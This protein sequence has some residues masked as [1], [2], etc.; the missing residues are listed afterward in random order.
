MALK[1][2]FGIPIV[3]S[4][5][6]NAINMFAENG[7]HN[8][9][10]VAEEL[11]R[12]EEGFKATKQLFG[13]GKTLNLTTSKS[14][15][16][17][18]GASSSFEAEQALRKLKPGSPVTFY[19]L[20]TIGTFGE[21]R[22]KKSDL[23]FF[24][25][26]EFALQDT[27]FTGN[28]FEPT[29]KA[30]S[31]SMG[32]RQKS[33][34]WAKETLTKLENNPDYYHQMTEAE[35]FALADL[36]LYDDNAKFGKTKIDGMLFATVEAQSPNK[37]STGWAMTDAKNI[38]RMREGL[39]NKTDSRYITPKTNVLDLLHNKG[40]AG[41]TYAGQN[42]RAFDQPGLAEVVAQMSE[43][44]GYTKRRSVAKSVAKAQ[45]DVL[46]LNTQFLNTPGNP[47]SRNKKLSVM[48]SA[49]G[50]AVGDTHF[51]QADVETTIKVANASIPYWNKNNVIQK[52]VQQHVRN[53]DIFI[54][55]RGTGKYK[56]NGYRRNAGKYDVTINRVGKETALTRSFQESPLIEGHGYKLVGQYDNVQ[57]DGKNM[58]ALRFQDVEDGTERIIYR[59][60]KAELANV[61]DS[62]LSRTKKGIPSKQLQAQIKNA[63]RDA[64]RRFY[65]SLYEP[66]LDPDMKA[67]QKRF[68]GVY[69]VLDTYTAQRDALAKTG[70]TGDDL[71]RQAILAAQ[72]EL[73]KEGNPL[74]KFLTGYEKV[75]K[76]AQLEGVL[77][78]ERSFMGGI[79]GAIGNDKSAHGITVQNQMVQTAHDLWLKR[80]GNAA[81]EF[82]FDGMRRLPISTAR[83]ATTYI[84]VESPDAIAER[85][86]K[87]LDYGKGRNVAKPFQNAK[88]FL[89]GFNLTAAERVQFEE[90]LRGE[91]SKSNSVSE[92]TT[93]AIANR[94]FEV[95]QTDERVVSRIPGQKLVAPIGPGKVMPAPLNEDQLDYL[96]T[97]VAKS[98]KL[99]D[100]TI[101]SQAVVKDYRGLFTPSDLVRE[102]IQRNDAISEFFDNQ[103]ATKEIFS[104]PKHGNTDAYLSE[105]LTA[106]RGKY[107]IAMDYVPETDRVVFSFGAPNVNIAGMTMEEK[108]LDER[109]TQFNLPFYNRDATVDVNG[110]GLTNQYD[111]VFGDPALG[112]AI[113]KMGITS[114]QD[115]AWTRIA[116][117]PER[118]EREMARAKATGQPISRVEAAKRAVQSYGSAITS[119]Q[120]SRT[121]AGDADPLQSY[122]HGS[123]QRNAISGQLIKM[124]DYSD[125]L[126][127][128]DHERVWEEYQIWK[129]EKHYRGN[130]L[131]SDFISPTLKFRGTQE[132]RRDVRTRLEYEANES[133][134]KTFGFELSNAGLNDKQY[135]TGKFYLR[136]MT[137]ATP[138][139]ER[140]Q[141]LR[142]NIVK[143]QNYHV[144]EGEPMRQ[145]LRGMGYSES[146]IDRKLQFGSSEFYEDL[147]T[148][149]QQKEMRG[150]VLNT[151]FTDE[152][153]LAADIKRATASTQ[154]IIADLNRQIQELMHE[155]K[156]GTNDKKMADLQNKL[157]EETAILSA[158]RKVSIDEGQIIQSQEIMQ[159][160]RIKDRIPVKLKAGEVLPDKFQELVARYATNGSIHGI[161]AQIRETEAAIQTRIRSGDRTGMAGLETELA[162]LQAQREAV[163]A[164]K[165]V[166]TPNGYKQTS[167]RFEKPITYEQMVANELVD[168]KGF[169]TVGVLTQEYVLGGIE[170][171]DE[172]VFDS[173]HEAHKYR[174][175]QNS[176]IVGYKDIN[177]RKELILDQV[178]QMKDGSKMVTAYGGDRGTLVSMPQAGLDR[179]YPPTNGVRIEQVMENLKEGRGQGGAMVMETIHTSQAAF[180]NNMDAVAGGQAE[181]LP[182]VSRFLTENPQYT[183][184]DLSKVEVQQAALA[185]TFVPALKPLGLDTKAA[186]A[187]SGA[188]LIFDGG[189]DAVG[190]DGV[191][192]QKGLAAFVQ[193]METG[194]GLDQSVLAMP[195]QVHDTAD[196]QGL[197]TKARLSMREIDMLE[198]TYGSDSA[199]F[200]FYKDMATH[201]EEAQAH[202]AYGKEVLSAIN[203]ND[204]VLTVQDLVRQGN[205]VIDLTG[206]YAGDQGSNVH[207]TESGAF[208]INYSKPDKRLPDL[209]DRTRIDAEGTMADPYSIRVY[210]EAL[211]LDTTIGDI[212]KE[213]GGNV[214][215]KLQNGPKGPFQTMAVAI[216]GNFQTGSGYDFESNIPRQIEADVE[217]I[218]RNA[219]GYYAYSVG[220]LTKDELAHTDGLQDE[221]RQGVNESTRDLTGNL[222]RY[223]TSTKPGDFQKG[224]RTLHVQQ[225]LSAKSGSFA[226]MQLYDQSNIR[227]ENGKL[228]SD[229]AMNKNYRMDTVYLSSENAAGMINGV[230]RQ[231]YAANGLKVEDL[232][233][234]LHL[235]MK[236]LTDQHI[237]DD[238]LMRMNREYGSTIDVNG[239]VT[240]QPTKT[241]GSLA[242]VRF[243][244]DDRAGKRIMLNKAIAFELDDDHDGDTVYA[245]LDHYRTKKNFDSKDVEQFK[246]LRARHMDIAGRIQKLSGNGAYS[247]QTTTERLM[248]D[249]L[250]T[251][252]QKERTGLF[253]EER[254]R[255]AGIG[256]EESLGMSE[257]QWAD[258]LTSEQLAQAQ[259]QAETQALANV[260]NGN[261]QYQNIL[262]T[263]FA[264]DTDQANDFMRTYTTGADEV[265]KTLAAEEKAFGLGGLDNSI[266]GIRR[267]KDFVLGLATDRQNGGFMPESVA[268]AIRTRD[269][270]VG[271]ALVQSLISTKKLTPKAVGL[272]PEME[273]AE[274]LSAADQHLKDMLGLPNG[275]QGIKPGNIDAVMEALTNVKFIDDGDETGVKTAGN[276][277]QYLEDTAQVNQAV[278]VFNGENN[279]ANQIKSNGAG[280]S[281]LVRAMQNGVFVNETPEVAQ[282]AE[283]FDEDTKALFRENQERGKSRILETYQTVL[284]P[285]TEKPLDVPDS[286]IDTTASQLGMLAE[287]AMQR[288][289]GDA[290]LGARVTENVFRFGEK[291]GDSKA[292]MVGAGFAGIWALTSAFRREP[293]PEGNESQQEATPVQVNPAALLTSPTA[294]VTPNGELVRMN[295]SAQG[296]ADQDTIAGLVNQ[297]IAGMTGVPLN[298]NIQTTDNTNKLDQS[299]FT[300]IVNKVLGF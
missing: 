274:Q 226:P 128:R 263:T 45:L 139:G 143:A 286:L 118:I 145:A 285:L 154:D 293:T 138:M 62:H 123:L 247:R 144:I 235:D 126:L 83:G 69:K 121:F 4:G 109:I 1:S 277:R 61:I 150:V 206:E 237:Q 147:A 95:S 260:T 298:M 113:P 42:V 34:R 2:K 176:Q 256:L 106:F 18:G 28:A 272:T 27:V 151:K 190:L 283:L 159:G 236:E 71:M 39:N 266:V 76:I 213:T 86:R 81:N 78:T 279:Y 114:T 231:I 129:G 107:S 60:N 102:K 197:G 278:N 141:P 57:V 273:M 297:Q 90:E 79:L 240:R 267:N 290:S 89:A 48:G 70:A 122:G 41:V 269:D 22:L 238:I 161:D 294:R 203:Q 288:R 209:R 115:R 282:L 10:T 228:V 178:T 289:A 132:L 224:A 5:F 211:G 96:Q 51:G 98:R 26:H 192:G 295:I 188:Y 131:E 258:K 164:G 153:T 156:T 77:Q 189:R 215:L 149:T 94:L 292:A 174:I 217:Q 148:A 284:R 15:R 179:L 221:L 271:G 225:G 46:G 182:L 255:M 252:Y 124:G 67:P 127:A 43:E 9:N 160:T 58:F 88:I 47:R 120:I 180:L 208:V 234:S 207:V 38:R 220:D 64:A 92:G 8:N 186:V 134:G 198:R 54:A 116:G 125:N 183:V 210:D 242:A 257:T 84:N 12:M 137:S 243:E 23:D 199:I 36:A 65:D 135:A 111:A 44:V 14:R 264:M 219:S 24:D 268:A 204:K 205:V 262:K 177:G 155:S 52:N 80:Y 296:N 291:L 212:Q 33:T 50:V 55:D 100:A 35:R 158:Y 31:I 136:N 32:M 25:I 280:D 253:A 97:V 133:L 167:I 222:N 87:S 184:G 29:G 214:F 261:L 105:M 130:F 75:E 17:V 191:T 230:E 300:N 68:D 196:Y 250:D 162:E 103:F 72:A 245:V 108:L 270:Q 59:S 91:L 6:P 195:S 82:G 101:A 175:Q 254:R 93:S 201:N 53:G 142:E 146:E 37:P 233:E 99:T 104:N 223:L 232:A 63:K 16:T 30:V 165:G 19:D 20:E 170:E 275:L 241:M 227:L 248:N 152:F 181:A 229:W 85:L 3:P 169:L 171:G 40:K 157:N 140:N 259:Q 239:F 251:S 299:F 185:N 7:V 168:D 56:E 173:V 287:T 49:L 13:T 21:N 216:P 73:N 11:A 265:L 218:Y 276:V 193:H 281:R 119:G 244:V 74:G 246:G 110:I 163:V 117:I 202:Y 66:Y 194:V 172:Q 166:P 112:T 249:L 200:Q 187:E